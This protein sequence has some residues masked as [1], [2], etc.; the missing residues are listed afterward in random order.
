MKALIRFIN[1]ETI[2]DTKIGKFRQGHVPL[3][4]KL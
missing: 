4:T 1:E 2:P 3:Q